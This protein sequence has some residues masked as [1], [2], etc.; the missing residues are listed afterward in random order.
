LNY[1]KSIE[2]LV[3]CIISVIIINCNMRDKLTNFSDYFRHGLSA[4]QLILAELAPVQI[5]VGSTGLLGLLG[6]RGLRGLRGL[7]GLQ[8]L[9]QGLRRGLRGRDIDINECSCDYLFYLRRGLLG[10]KNDLRGDKCEVG[11]DD[12]YNYAKAGLR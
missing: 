3:Y 10:D 8:G 2:E 12:N 1:L 11:C 7:Q 5:L 6:L 9:R 4:I